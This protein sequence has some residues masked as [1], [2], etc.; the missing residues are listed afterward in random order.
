MATVYEFEV[1][2]VDDKIKVTPDTQRIDAADVELR[3]NGSEILVEDLKFA[4][5]TSPAPAVTQSDDNPL[6]V[7]FTNDFTTE[8]TLTY[9][10]SEKFAFRKD[11]EIVLEPP[12]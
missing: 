11:P 6:V 12:R 8:T 10:L 7:T 2:L 3:F 1:D 9:E 4:W 5:K